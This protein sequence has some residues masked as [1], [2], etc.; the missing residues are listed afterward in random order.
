MSGKKIKILLIEDDRTDQMAFLRFFDKEALP[1]DCSIAG[2]VSEASDILQ[3]E[4]FDAVVMDYD[5]GEG[6]AFDLIPKVPMDIPVIIVTG[7]GDEEIA[8]RAMKAGASD[9]LIK[10]IDGRYLKVLPIKMDK[11]MKAKGWERDLRRYHDSLEE[12]VSERTQRLKESNRQL[13]REIKERMRAEQTTKESEEKFRTIFD[14]AVDGILIADPVSKSFVMGNETVCAMLGCAP[15]EIKDL[16]VVDILPPE[17]RSH[18]LEQFEK[19]GEQRFSPAT[20]VPV[21]RKDGSVFYADINSAPIEIGGREY[22]MGIYRDITARK[23]AEEKLRESEEQLLQS[24]KMEAIGRLA[25]GVAHD[26]NNM[27][28]VVLGYSEILLKRLA[29]DEP[30]R[31]IVEKIREAGERAAS[32]TNQL[33][34]FSR[35]KM[36]QPKILDL[37]ALIADM[38]KMIRRLIGEHIELLFFPGKELAPVLA[39]PAQIDQI[40]MNLLVNAGDA[41]AKV[42][43]I[44]LETANVELDETFAQR[45]PGAKPGPHVMIAVSDTGVGM[46][47][48]TRSRIFEPFFTT[49]KDGKGTGLGL[50]TVYG[51][52]KQSMGSIWVY[53]E[54]GKG[55]TFKIYLP[56]VEGNAEFPD[57]VKSYPNAHRGAETILLVEDE[58]M[59]RELARS[60]LAEMGYTVLQAGNGAEAIH[61]V[62]SHKSPIHLLVTDVVMPAMGGQ[63]LAERV[64]SLDP[65]TRVIYMSGYT[66]STIAHHG[67]L[68]EGIDFLQ[69][70]FTPGDLARKVREV[71]DRPRSSSSRT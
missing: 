5:L 33:L 59:I 15:E 63:E 67:V 49:K 29:E 42:G 69:K 40:L 51:I 1:Y 56:K 62:E 71:L 48:E 52:V 7:A 32:L 17:R 70:P 65:K 35:K 18:V 24:Q 10:D 21:K 46:D 57:K 8:I 25:G 60:A 39:D 44:T 61:V 14:N 26:F 27:M 38:E 19:W 37:N 68:A 6:N 30:S 45:H 64:K 36:I 31:N 13:H 23:H 66:D 34:A 43:K 50:S 16:S 54:P 41:I 47:R 9:Y 28:L 53:S 11:A 20:D 4:A 12:M 3:A 22:L 55:T 2:S 58:E